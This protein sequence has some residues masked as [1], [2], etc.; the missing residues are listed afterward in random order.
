VVSGNIQGKA[1]GTLETGKSERA[2]EDCAE[3]L[4]APQGYGGTW[5]WSFL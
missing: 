2:G 5:G 1:S 3:R 4:I